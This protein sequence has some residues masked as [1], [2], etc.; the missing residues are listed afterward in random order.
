[1]DAEIVCGISF[2]MQSSIQPDLESEW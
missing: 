2:W 1:M